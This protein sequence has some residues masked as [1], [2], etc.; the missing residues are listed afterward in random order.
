[1]NKIQPHKIFYENRY[2]DNTLNIMLRVPLFSFT[3]TKL[4][5]VTHFNQYVKNR[6]H[7]NNMNITI[8]D[9][10]HNPHA[11]TNSFMFFLHK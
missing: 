4:S 3:N 6:K 2:K 8:L 5:D 1:M 11:V 7:S 9:L 10:S